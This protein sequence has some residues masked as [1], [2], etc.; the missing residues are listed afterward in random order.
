[1][2]IAVEMLFS[3]NAFMDILAQISKTREGE[4]DGERAN[5]PTGTDDPLLPTN[6]ATAAI[7]YYRSYL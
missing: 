2:V 3:D 6:Y 1:L 7:G 4:R 5:S